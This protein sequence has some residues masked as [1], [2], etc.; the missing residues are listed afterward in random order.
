MSD[1]RILDRDAFARAVEACGADA[2]AYGAWILRSA[3]DDRVVARSYKSLRDDAVSSADRG[4]LFQTFERNPGK[5]RL[6]SRWF[7]FRDGPRAVRSAG[8][9]FE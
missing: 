3:T 1:Y 9:D 4:V 6:S 8:E 5:F 2:D 7:A